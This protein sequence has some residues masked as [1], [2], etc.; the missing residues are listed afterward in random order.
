MHYEESMVTVPDEFLQQIRQA[1]INLSNKENVVIKFTAYTDN[2]PLEGRDERI[3]GDHL[4]MSKAVARRV[5]L[6]VHD[7]LRLTDVAVES[8]GKGATQQAASNDTP[9]GRAMN[10]RV[11]VEFWHD[12]PLQELPDEPQLCP[13]CRA[14]TVTKA[15][16]PSGALIRSVQ[17]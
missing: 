17:R 13:G 10:R 2:T 9:Q 15:M 14:E 8:V 16:T 12:D 1:L 4:G 3:Y 7:A 11:E 5:S 6:A